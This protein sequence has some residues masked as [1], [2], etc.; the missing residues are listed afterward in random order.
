MERFLVIF[1]PKKNIRD[2][3]S[4]WKLAKWPFFV[5]SNR[6]E[7]YWIAREP[8]CHCYAM[9]MLSCV[10]AGA[11]GRI[12]QILFPPSEKPELSESFP[13]A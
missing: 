11:S 6:S 10:Q 3:N 2:R 4:E 1:N 12:M 13:Q 5:E 7:A 9:K 8:H